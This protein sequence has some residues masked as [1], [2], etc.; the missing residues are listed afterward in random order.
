MVI[1]NYLEQI[2]CRIC[3]NSK[4]VEIV[5]L[6]NQFLSGI[7]PKSIDDQLI[8]GPLSLVKCCGLNSCGLVQMKH[9]FDRDIMYGDNY[10]YRSGLNSSMVEHLKTKTEKLKSIIDLNNEDVVL[11]IGSNDGT[12][13][14]FF[15][16]NNLNLIG[17]DPTAKNFINYYSDEITIIPEYFSENLFKNKYGKRKAKIIMSFSMFYD[18]PQPLD[19]MNEIKSILKEDGIWALEQSYLP[20]MLKTNSYDTICHEHYEYYSLKAIKFMTDKL[21]LKIIDIEFN[22]VNGGSFSLII[23]HKDSEYSEFN[24]LGDL[25]TKEKNLSDLGTYELFETRIKKAKRDINE[26]LLNLR[27]DGHTV[28]GIGASTKGNVLLQYCN[29]D[30]TLIKCIGEVNKSKYGCFTPGS[31]IPIVSEDEVLNNNNYEYLLILPW[32]F[33]NFFINSKKFK[34]KKLIFA[35][36]QVEIINN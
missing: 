1:N 14:N 35:L 33:K 26:T 22:N 36:P 34:G 18:L 4:L 13:L 23:A 27:N 19:F 11:D 29:I 16:N 24:S 9:N 10:G 21:D 2:N 7:F 32:H 8:S 31:N 28:A 30:S 17:I 3:N 25:L 6:G 5:S 20:F 15:K 12:T